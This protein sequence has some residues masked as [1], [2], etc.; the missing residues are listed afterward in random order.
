MRLNSTAGSPP[1]TRN[2]NMVRTFPF[3]CLAARPLEQP[4]KS[5]FMPRWHNVQSV[6]YSTPPTAPLF[7]GKLLVLFSGASVRSAGQQGVFELAGCHQAVDV[8]VDGAPA[9]RELL[10]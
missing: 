5:M 6:F 3:G 2:L 1:I 4:G 10:G 7:P 8:A 9:D